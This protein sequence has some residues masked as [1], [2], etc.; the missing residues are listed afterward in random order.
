[1]GRRRLI[2]VHD[3][4]DIIDWEVATIIGRESD[5]TT[6]WIREAVKIRQES[7]DVMNRNEGLPVVSRLRRFTTHHGY[8]CSDSYSMTYFR[9]PIS[10]IVS[11]V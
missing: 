4:L 8:N 5:R 1:M 6:R 9:A 11:R 2:S 7:Q 10:S 3:V